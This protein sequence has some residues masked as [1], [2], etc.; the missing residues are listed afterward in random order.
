MQNSSCSVVYLV[1]ERFREMFITSLRW[2]KIFVFHTFAAPDL[3][4]RGKTSASPRHRTA[5]RRWRTF[6][7][8]RSHRFQERR[9]SRGEKNKKNCDD[10][11]RCG[12]RTELISCASFDI[13]G[14]KRTVN[15]TVHAVAKE[16]DSSLTSPQRRRCRTKKKE[17]SS[18]STPKHTERLTQPGPTLSINAGAVRALIDNSEV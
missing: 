14:I 16:P 18:S 17:K 15:T 13:G 4:L 12:Q 2:K 3:C 10:Y 7:S 6:G 8:D 9:Q 11:R 1:S 5:P